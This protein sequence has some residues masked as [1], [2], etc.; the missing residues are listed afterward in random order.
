[1]YTIFTTEAPQPLNLRNRGS[2][3]RDLF[4]K[5]KRNDW[6][7]LPKEHHAR[8]SAAAST[9]LKGRYSLYRIDDGSSDYCLLKLR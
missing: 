8:A 9:Y 5:M 7:R 1:M 2:Y 3:W 4:E 6:I